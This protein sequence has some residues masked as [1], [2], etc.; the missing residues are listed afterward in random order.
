MFLVLF[1]CGIEIETRTK[2]DVLKKKRIKIG[3]LIGN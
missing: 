2:I 3:G 1:V